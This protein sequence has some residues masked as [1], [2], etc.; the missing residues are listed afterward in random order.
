VLFQ[1]CFNAVSTLF[2]RCFN[3]VSTLF[4]RCFNAVSKLFQRCFNAVF[5]QFRI[6]NIRSSETGELLVMQEHEI[7]G[8]D[9]PSFPL[10]SLPKSMP[11]D[12]DH[13]KWVG[14]AQ[15]RRPTAV[16]PSTAANEGGDAA[17]TAVYRQGAPW[18]IS[19]L[20]S[21]EWEGPK[22]A[23]FQFAQ[24]GRLLAIQNECP[25]MAQGQLGHGDAADLIDI[26][27]W[28][29]SSCVA[30]VACPVHSFVF[31]L[32]TGVCVA[33]SKRGSKASAKVYR[34]ETTLAGNILLAREPTPRVEAERGES[35]FREKDGNRMQMH[36]VEAALDAK[37]G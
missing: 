15:Q 16:P 28:Q 25:H 13:A 20:T 6:R 27:D 8:L 21:P 2:Q 31:D 29:A 3:A 26:E 10:T 35:E 24:R 23:I 7:R 14:V 1:R 33:G 9:H 36:L 12:W 11:S 19:D 34:V 37:F 4:Q 17:S 32:V 30:A 18:L 22:V 5:R